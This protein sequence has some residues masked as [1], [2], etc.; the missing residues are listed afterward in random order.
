MTSVKIITFND[1]EEH[2]EMSLIVLWLK[3]FSDYVAICA[4]EP[5]VEKIVLTT[6]YGAI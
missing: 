3:F 1:K 4:Q 2:N 5:T 6:L